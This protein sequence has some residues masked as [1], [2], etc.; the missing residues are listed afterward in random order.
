MSS[1]GEKKVIFSS[2]LWAS[3]GTIKATTCPKLFCWRI[4]DPL[5]KHDPIFGA[6]E[7]NAKKKDQE[8][9]ILWTENGQ[10]EKERK[11]IECPTVEIVYPRI[12]LQQTNNTCDTKSGSRKASFDVWHWKFLFYLF[13]LNLSILFAMPKYRLYT[14][15]GSNTRAKMVRICGE[16]MP[17]IDIFTTNLINEFDLS[18][19]LKLERCS[20]CHFHSES[21]LLANLKDLFSYVYFIL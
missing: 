10:P 6:D 15:K 2:L 17:K 4:F 20:N 1:S 11:K 7:K 8:K 3:V 16:N 14:T 18:A 13:N 5:A 9:Q 19:N 12:S 21:F